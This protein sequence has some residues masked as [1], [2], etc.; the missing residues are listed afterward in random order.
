[1]P[2]L[3]GLL[4]YV[5]EPNIVEGLLK[6]YPKLSKYNIKFTN[7]INQPTDINGQPVKSRLMEFYYPGDTYYN[8]N[9]NDPTIEQFSPKVTKKDAFGEIFSHLLPEV[10]PNFKSGREA[11]MR[12]ITPEQEKKY[13]RGDYEYQAQTGLLGPSPS[14]EQWK[15]K[16]GGDAF[17]RGFPT[18]QY[19]VEAYTHEQKILLNSLMNYLKK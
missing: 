6:D 7:S 10:D 19:P 5:Q 2:T 9:Y 17:F 8:P 13:L 3:G 15:N 4:G 14:Y 1:M 18:Q 11:F 12:S 16:Q